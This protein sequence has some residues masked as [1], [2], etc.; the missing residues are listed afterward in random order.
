MLSRGVVLCFETCE[1]RVRQSRLER[2]ESFFLL[3][4][5][6]QSTLPFLLRSTV[7]VAQSAKLPRRFTLA[8]QLERSC[9][10]IC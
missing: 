10:V 4:F 9:D 2:H 7:A 8:E 6:S 5:E 3:R 1:T